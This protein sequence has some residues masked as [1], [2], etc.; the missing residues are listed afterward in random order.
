MKSF[1][2]EWLE[3]LEAKVDEQEKCITKLNQLIQLKKPKEIPKIPKKTI[4][5]LY[6]NSGVGK[7]TIGKKLRETIPEIVS[8]TTRPIRELET[9]GDEYYFV[10]SLIDIP[11]IE[12]IE[13]AGF[14][15]GI[16]KKEVEKKLAM[17]DNC[18][19]ILE[20]E[21]IK[22]FKKASKE[23]GVLEGVEIEVIEIVSD[24]YEVFCR[25]LKRG[26]L[27]A[28]TR[29]RKNVELS[30]EIVYVNHSVYN[31]D[32]AIEKTIEE[33]LQK[34]NKKVAEKNKI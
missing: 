13:Y 11:C 9:D 17:S 29:L 19:V 20:A 4:W 15:Y 16:S 33:V 12:S 1:M 14:Y 22:Q 24:N 7:T 6:G 27:N 3:K 8:H 18:F 30:K 34:I 32:G 5:V 31:N 25:L 23:Q 2:F 21:G 26:P 10:T 28:Y